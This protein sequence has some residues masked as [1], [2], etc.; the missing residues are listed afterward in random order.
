MRTVS[1]FKIDNAILPIEVPNKPSSLSFITNSSI[2]MVI[3]IFKTTFISF[4]DD[5]GTL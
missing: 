5:I 3:Q 2:G 4:S 1:L